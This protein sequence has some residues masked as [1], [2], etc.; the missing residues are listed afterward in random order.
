[1]HQTE[2]WCKYILQA[3]NQVA[4]LKDIHLVGSSST[5]YMSAKRP[6]AAIISG[7]TA[8]SDCVIDST[9]GNLHTVTT[10]LRGTHRSAR[11]DAVKILISVALGRRSQRPFHLWRRDGHG[12]RSGL[13][14]DRPSVGFLPIPHC[15]RSWRRRWRS[16]RRHPSPQPAASRYSRRPSGIHPK[17]SGPF[18]SGESFFTL[19]VHRRG[20]QRVRSKR[21][22]CSHSQTRP[23]RL[24][25]QRRHQNTLQL[26]GRPPAGWPTSCHRIP[27]PQR[28]RSCRPPLSSNALPAI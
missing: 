16:D 10:I 17:S 28:R 8:V 19:P 9:L 22:R 7:S 25:R 15:G 3:A 23:A 2:P 1:M 11:I 24:R 6:Y 26:P 4:V 21:R 18:R 5:R 14:A 27:P 12:S 20:P 13:H